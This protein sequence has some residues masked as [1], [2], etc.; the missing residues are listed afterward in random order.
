[1]VLWL[2]LIASSCFEIDGVVVSVFAVV[3]LFVYG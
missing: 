2:R 3:L 1:M